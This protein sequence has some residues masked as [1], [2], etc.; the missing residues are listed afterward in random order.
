MTPQ[1]SLNAAKC[2]TARKLFSE[3]M[4]VKDI[5]KIVGI[6]ETSIYD[7]IRDLK[8]K[9]REELTAQAQ[10][11]FSEGK[12]VAEICRIMEFS[13][14][15]VRGLISGLKSQINTDKRK[16]MAKARKMY[17]AGMPV[18]HISDAIG[19]GRHA[20]S[21][22]VSDLRVQSE[23]SE[24]G[25]LQMTKKAR[26]KGAAQSS[27]PVAASFVECESTPSVPTGTELNPE[28]VE[29]LLREL[30]ATKHQLAKTA[31]ERDSNAAELVKTAAER[32]YQ[33][34]RADAYDY[35][36]KIAE[37]RHNISI[38]KKIGTKQ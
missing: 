7:W 23:E 12:S 6:S 22:W 19:V 37:K 32:D 20:V 8:A 21:R 9:Q 15:K 13:E 24:K 36:I 16:S 26:N 33:T 30:E 10:K 25:D 31:A 3:G 27:A 5:A 34:M 2:V 29:Q 17:L 38:V 18:K 4:A 1:K 28:Y 14:A 35:L 11:L